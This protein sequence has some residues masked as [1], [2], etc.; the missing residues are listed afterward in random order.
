MNTNGTVDS[1]VI[2]NVWNG[3]HVL[4]KV[5]KAGRAAIMSDNW[6]L[7][8]QLPTCHSSDLNNCTTHWMYE[9]T[10]Q[11]MYQ[12]DPENG[13]DSGL[14]LNL[15]LGG[16]MSAW[17]ESYDYNSNMDNR[18]WNRGPAIAERL[19]SPK[20]VTDLFSAQGRLASFRCK[21]LRRGIQAGP[22]E[23]D[24][25]DVV[26]HVSTKSKEPNSESTMLITAVIICLSVISCVAIT[27]NVVQY[28]YWHSRQ[29]THHY[30]SIPL[31]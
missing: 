30:S 1:D 23:P 26:L 18:L 13:L 17:A 31:K 4:S 21:L 8:K 10:W 7:D 19:W 6:Y 14:N 29:Q 12:A 15:L 3:A 22:S 16:E 20:N 25:C 11:D 9:S 27:L 5:L 24:Y 2:I 28:L